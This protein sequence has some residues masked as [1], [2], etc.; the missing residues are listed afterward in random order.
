MKSNIRKRFTLIRD[1]FSKKERLSLSQLIQNKLLSLED[2]INSKTV[3]LYSSFKSEV[4]TE[5]LIKRS[6]EKKTTL[7]PLTISEKKTITPCAINNLHHDT[8]NGFSGILEPKKYC[9]AYEKE[10]IDLVVVPGVAFGL[11]GERLGYGGGYYD[12]FLK[13]YKGKIIGI[14]FEKQ[15]TDLIKPEKH[16]VLMHKIVTEKR[17]IKC[18]K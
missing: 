12:R 18:Q 2:Y 3:L 13:G 10:K 17:I 11:K 4:N 16:D 5:K 15:L 1:S 6:V 7:L 14:C 9:K 8:A